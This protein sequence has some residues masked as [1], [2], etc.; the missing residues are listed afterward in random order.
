MGAVIE[1]EGVDIDPTAVINVSE[2]LVIGK[3][4]KVSAGCVIEGRDIEI[5]NGFWMLPGAVIGGGSAFEKP[6]VLRA[7][8]FL[9]M[10]RNSLINTARAVYIGDEVGLGTGTSIFTHGAYLSE[11]EG[12]PVSFAP[13]IIGD[14]VWL[15]GATVNPGVTIGDNVVVG[16]GAV[17]T[18]DIPSGALALGSP[19]KVV[20]ERAYPQRMTDVEMLSWWEAFA[21]EF[22]DQHIA[23]R[24]TFNPE[25][26]AILTAY[27]AFELDLPRRVE[28]VVDRDS[29]RLRD[30][31]RRHGIRFYASPVDGKYRAW[32]G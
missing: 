20:K 4:S 27:A 12:F 14:N 31:L 8:H 5:G 3:E 25:R 26:R 6:S 11:I 19:A 17:V 24:L 16:V 32:N 2:R 22:P 18:H 13:V 9:H 10:G 15:P 1:V 23:E 7:G 30:E 28:G 21:D 29:E